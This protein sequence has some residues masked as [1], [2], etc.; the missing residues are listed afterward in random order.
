MT[1]I[2]QKQA[3]AYVA[4]CCPEINFTKCF[5]IKLLHAN[6]QCVYIVYAKYRLFQQ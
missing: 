3:G 2:Q 5:G 1:G 6:V 4:I